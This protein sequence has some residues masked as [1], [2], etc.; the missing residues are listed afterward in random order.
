MTNNPSIPVLT[1]RGTHREV[2]HQIGEA[3]QSHIRRRLEHLRGEIPSGVSWENAL[4]QARL[5]LAYTRA[6]YPQYVEEIE[7]S[8]IHI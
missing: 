5:C 1:L 8:L 7:L 4:H 2:G 3:W 6:V